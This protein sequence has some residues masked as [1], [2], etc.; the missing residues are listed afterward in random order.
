M[1][2][3]VRLERCRL[4]T[5]L[6]MGSPGHGVLPRWP[7]QFIMCKNLPAGG[8]LKGS[9]GA[10]AAGSQRNSGLW[11]FFFFSF[12]PDLKRT[13]RNIQSTGCWEQNPRRNPSFWTKQNNLRKL[14]LTQETNSLFPAKCFLLSQPRPSA[15][16]TILCAKRRTQFWDPSGLAQPLC[17]LGQATSALLTSASSSLR[18]KGWARSGCTNLSDCGEA[19]YTYI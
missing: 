5:E 3:A 9:R 18:R 14:D 10:E 7:Q 1:Q 17:D 2:Q 15:L 16:D 6:S 13:V 11:S 12:S 19:V 4:A 8:A